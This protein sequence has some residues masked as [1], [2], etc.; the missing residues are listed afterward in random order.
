MTDGF[1]HSA[2]EYC[3]FEAL[4]ATPDDAHLHL[5]KFFEASGET[6]DTLNQFRHLWNIAHTNSKVFGQDRGIDVKQ[7]S[8]QLANKI[9]IGL[10]LSTTQ[11]SARMLALQKAK[12]QKGNH[13]T[14]KNNLSANAA[15]S[16]AAQC[17]LNDLRTERRALDRAVAI[18]STPEAPSTDVN[19][20]DRML[21]IKRAVRV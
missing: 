7:L 8:E 5:Y 10:N 18:I 13:L 4:N 16:Y 17:E 20:S 2:L 15:N 6:V 3:I 19:Y 12:S 14:A 1:K 9:D 11:H 21:E